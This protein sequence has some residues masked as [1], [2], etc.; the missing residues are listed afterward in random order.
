[1]EEGRKESL[2]GQLYGPQ[3]ACLRRRH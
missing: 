1:M 2:G 3:D